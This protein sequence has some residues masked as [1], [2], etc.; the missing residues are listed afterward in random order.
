MAIVMGILDFDGFWGVRNS[1]QFPDKRF[2]SGNKQPKHELKFCPKKN[3]GKEK[4]KHHLQIMDFSLAREL[5]TWQL[6]PSEQIG[7]THV[8]YYWILKI[9]LLKKNNRVMRLYIIVFM[10]FCVSTELQSSVKQAT[11]E[12]LAYRNKST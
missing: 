1:S 4:Y 11:K 8:D 10:F 3:M 5:L 9:K 2:D 12:M 6:Q 7:K